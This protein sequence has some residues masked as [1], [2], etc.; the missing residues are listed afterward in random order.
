[1]RRVEI[2]QAFI[3]TCDECGRDNFER[4][5][6]QEM[7]PEEREQCFREY[8]RMEDHEELPDDWQNFDMVMAPNSVKCPACGEEFDTYN[9]G[10]SE[11]HN[12][13]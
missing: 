3:W 8:H 1:M 2:H 11:A 4:A 7:G 13:Q 9:T 12:E 5:I 10:E 6:I